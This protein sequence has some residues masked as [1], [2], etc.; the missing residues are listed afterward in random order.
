[1]QTFYSV[2]LNS[3]KSLKVAFSN[4][5]VIKAPTTSVANL[6]RIPRV[7]PVNIFMV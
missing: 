7:L 4:K 1:M 3:R 5:N 2:W 6:L